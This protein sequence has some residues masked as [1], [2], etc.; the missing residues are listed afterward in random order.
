MSSD[1]IVSWNKGRLLL[2]LDCWCFHCKKLWDIKLS[3]K[4][5]RA[6]LKLILV[7]IIVHSWRVGMD[8]ELNELRIGFR[9]SRKYI[10]LRSHF[11]LLKHF[12]EKKKNVTADIFSISSFSGVIVLLYYTE[13]GCGWCLC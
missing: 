2:K 13:R 3:T 12:S 7:H 10:F 4:A 6:E 11:A 5:N 1:T 8:F 9:S